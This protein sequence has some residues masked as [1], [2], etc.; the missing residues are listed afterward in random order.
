[1]VG[2][3]VPDLPLP[4]PQ[5]GCP[6]ADGKVDLAVRPPADRARERLLGRQ[7]R[8][9]QPGEVATVVEDRRDAQV[10][11]AERGVLTRRARQLVDSPAPRE[12]RARSQGDVDLL[13]EDP[14]VVGTDHVDG[15]SAVQHRVPVDVGGPDVAQVGP[16][17]RGHDRVEQPGPLRG[18]QVRVGRA[19][20]QRGEAV[21]RVGAGRP[22]QHR[23]LERAPLLAVG[24]LARG[25][26]AGAVGPD[27]EVDAQLQ[28]PGVV[29]DDGRR[30]LGAAEDLPAGH[31]APEVVLRPA[32]A[33]VGP[34][35]PAGPQQGHPLAA[36]HQHPRRRPRRSVARH[37]DL[38]DRR[39]DPGQTR[40]R[41]LVHAHTLA[42]PPAR[43]AASPQT[44]WRQWAVR[45]AS[46]T[47]EGI[48]PR[49]EIFI[50]CAFAHS[51][52]AWLCSRSAAGRDGACCY[53][54]CGVRRSG[55]RPK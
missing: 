53:R 1:M 45:Y 2:P 3:H 16:P 43:R 42:A 35:D 51:R 11:V 20:L 9:P 32:V 27:A 48:R 13:D 44:S 39:P 19:R 30:V 18:D 34:A 6:A 7:R 24:T 50:P 40:G 21:D 55:E 52:I 23:D 5:P 37:H 15:G 8:A 25:E 14:G 22:A 4:A 38:H 10:V 36:A 29:D 41:L 47:S 31:A 46:R 26:G 33:G 12:L 28:R 49:S 54:S 17:R